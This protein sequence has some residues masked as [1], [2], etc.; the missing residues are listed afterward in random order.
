MCQH[1]NNFTPDELDIVTGHNLTEN[2]IL[3][4]NDLYVKLS[5]PSG[6]DILN[7]IATTID[8]YYALISKLDL[9]D[10]E[11]IRAVK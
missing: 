3:I 8:E 9:I 7:N 10:S 11:A 2:P 6:I 5:A 1:S 4:N